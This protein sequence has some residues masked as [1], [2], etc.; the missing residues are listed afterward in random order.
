MSERSV[1]DVSAVN[2]GDVSV[3]EDVMGLAP[4]YTPSSLLKMSEYISSGVV[5]LSAI[6]ACIFVLIFSLKL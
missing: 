3:D 1:G 2:V 4:K 6:I 5:N